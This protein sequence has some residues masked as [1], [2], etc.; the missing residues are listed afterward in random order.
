MVRLQPRWLGIS[1]RAVNAGIVTAA[2]QGDNDINASLS[3]IAVETNEV[4][5]ASSLL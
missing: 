1:I 5:A 2:P 4:L 3:E